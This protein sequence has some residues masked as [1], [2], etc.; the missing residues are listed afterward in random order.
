MG[1]ID[2]HMAA[3]ETNRSAWSPRRGWSERVW[4]VAAC[5]LVGWFYG[6]TARH[7]GVS[8]NFGQR[9]TDYYNLLV[10][11]FLDGHLYMKVDVP[12]ALLKLADP[13]NPETRPAGIALHD[14]SMYRGRY[15]IYFGAAP[16][17]TLL[18]PFRVLTGGV[19]LP[20]P[21]AVLVFTYAG[22]LVSGAILL[23][24]R[25]RY[26]PEA[27]SVGVV[28]W[29]VALGTASMGPLLVL[30]GSIWELPLSSGYFYAMVAL[31]CVGRAVHAERRA[32]WWLAG[33]GLGL[34]LAVASRP[35]Y[36]FASGVLMVPLGWQWWRGRAAGRAG[37][38][39]S[40]KWVFAGVVP[41]GAV[42]LAMAWY[43]Y[44]RFGNPTEFGVAY[45]FS[46]I[47]EAETQH[48]RWSYL[49]LNLRMYW[50][51]AAE[52][53]RYFPFVH[54]GEAPPVP[55]GH[56]GF[57]D[58]YG[59]AANVPLV[60]LALLAPLAVWRRDGERGPL[61][62]TLGAA[63]M[64]TLGTATPLAFFYAA[65]ARYGA[66][67]MPALV[68][69]AGTGALAL[70]RWARIEG[71]RTR[72]RVVTVGS[73]ALVAVSIFFAV[74]L[75]LQA[76]ND[77]RRQ[78]PRAY[79]RIATWLNYPSWWAG[80]LAGTDYG[81]VD[82]DGNFVAK[83]AGTREPLVRTGTL[84]ARDEIFLLHEGEGRGRIGFAHDG[85][86]GRE[87]GTIALVGAAGR[88]LRVEL[89]SLYP[90]E[91]HP[92]F[93][94]MSAAER[95]R[96]A[97]RL[98]VTLGDA[99]VLEGYQRFHISSPADVVLSRGRRVGGIAEIR[100]AAQGLDAAVDVEFDMI[101]MRVTFPG[102]RSGGREPLVVTGET[103]RGDFLFVEYVD[104]GGVQFGLDHW[105][106]AT[107]RSARVAV[108]RGKSYVIEIGLGAFPGARRPDELEVK[109]DGR[110]VW[111]REAKFFGVG[112]ED[113]FVGKN[114][115]GGTG[116]AEMFSGTILD[117]VRGAKP[118]SVR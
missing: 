90:P 26:F 68:L 16:V 83:A 70:Q 92:F 12:E 117:V 4:V 10:D 118:D 85:G 104:G 49:P 29:V 15:Y 97:R 45:Q 111:A 56:L 108:E 3:F 11:G 115:I 8:W 30:R 65:M 47:F 58:L 64:I 5:V 57:D 39:K 109:M 67:F 42:G 95:I 94:E 116:C 27:G 7:E 86:P 24:M 55:A 35:T 100:A 99:T 76:Y 93:A 41:L 51:Q 32:A 74:L 88:R 53:T 28:M 66:D 33:A 60:W 101:R 113:V 91:A 96:L 54:P 105:G 75:S 13:Y 84:G 81:P 34:G 20:L 46:G 106:K 40:A 18:L 22:F 62:T 59:V 61:V 63:L 17:V 87:S 73:C 6:W 69:L 107:V 112:A 89:G 25:R 114:P 52:W 1:R 78:S 14:A 36:L 103:G 9:Q 71:G 44:A 48:F 80:K 110:V 19:G 2:G 23:G 37:W 72:A 31:G 98:V 102:E 79:A 50:T 82:L 38:G 43:N 21:A 77:L